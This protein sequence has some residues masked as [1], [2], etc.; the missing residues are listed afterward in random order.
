MRILMAALLALSSAPA[1]AAYIQM[2]YTS[3]VTSL[4]IERWTLP[5]APAETR[6]SL[7]FETSGATLTYGVLAQP[8]RVSCLSHYLISNLAMTIL[9]VSVGGQSIMSGLTA[10]VSYGGDR[11]SG[12]S[13]P[14]DQ[15][16]NLQGFFD[17]GA[18]GSWSSGESFRMSTDTFYEIGI[19]DLLASTD[20]VA[21]LLLSRSFGNGHIF[22]GLDAM[23]GTTYF[24]DVAVREVPEPATLGLLILGCA[25]VLG[26]RRRASKPS[27]NT[28]PVPRSSAGA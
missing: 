24:T 17:G 25:G 8:D 22:L 23:Q 12:C 21:T 6:V 15:Y 7:L 5:V 3:P 1:C 9:D 20:P 27:H 10:A 13:L 16:E 4:D 18:A 28:Q 11:P 2:D 26:A 19:P 14:G